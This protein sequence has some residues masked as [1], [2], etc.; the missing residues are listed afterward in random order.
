M[1][2][3]SYTFRLEEK[4]MDDIKRYAEK[5][6]MSVGHMVEKLLWDHFYYYLFYR[7]YANIPDQPPSK[8]GGRRVRAGRPK[9]EAIEVQGEGDR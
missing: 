8:H 7:K 9:V 4:L 5:N 2:R 1:A 3:V 6:Q